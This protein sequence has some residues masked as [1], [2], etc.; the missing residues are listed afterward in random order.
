MNFKIIIKTF[1]P[2]KQLQTGHKG[3][4]HTLGMLLMQR[5]HY[6]LLVTPKEG[7][8]ATVRILR[9]LQGSTTTTQIIKQYTW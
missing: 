1:E 2:W 3:Q 6:M 7:N 9:K 8:T 5:P 4:F